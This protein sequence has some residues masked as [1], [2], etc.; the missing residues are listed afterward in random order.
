MCSLLS[1][2]VLLYLAVVAVVLA[3]GGLAWFVQ[4]AP[5]V[6]SQPSD[7]PPDKVLRF[8][9]KDPVS[10]GIHAVW[11]WD[12]ERPDGGSRKNSGYVLE[13]ERGVQGYYHFAFCNVLD[14]PAEMG[15]FASA[16]DCSEAAV[17]VLPPSQWDAIDAVLAKTP[18]VTP[19]FDPEPVWH[20]ISMT[21]PESVKVPA[22]ACGLLRI[23][24]KGRKEY[25]EPLNIHMSLYCQPDGNNRAREYYAL[26]VP[27]RIAPPL[28][29]DPKVAKVALRASD[30]QTIEFYC[31]SPTRENPDVSFQS[32]EPDPLFQVDSRRLSPTE[33]KELETTLRYP[34]SSGQRDP[35]IPLKYR[36]RS[37]Y[38]IKVT[39]SANKDGRHRDLGHSSR[40]LPVLLDQLQVDFPTPKIATVVAGDIEVGGPKDQGRIL[41]GDF[42]AAADRTVVVPISTADTANLEVVSHHPAL[43]QV[44]LTRAGKAPA[45]ARAQWDLKVTVPALTWRSGALPENSEVV[46]R[47]AGTP[48]SGKRPATPTRLMRIPVV[49][50][51]TR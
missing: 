49:G 18:W 45:P 25:D 5:R 41:L 29:F 51:A 20:T 3:A 43:L 42:P 33:C 7:T 9:A 44:K 35:S 21:N 31:W 4:Q 6:R 37:A 28:R 34:E 46:L 36:V 22:H 30:T 47:V 11:E 10:G 32:P 8:R 13:T 16:C 17:C 2:N 48:A 14:S 12:Y 50:T 15:L 19:T 23:G 39:L 26:T 24:W 27:V 1:R 40:A 38:C